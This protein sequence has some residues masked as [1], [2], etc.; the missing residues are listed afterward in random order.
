MPPVASTAARPRRPR[1]IPLPRCPEGELVG[2]RVVIARPEFP[3]PKCPPGR[4]G[5][6][7]AA[8]VHAPEP[9]RYRD[10]REAPR[11]EPRTATWVQ[12][13]AADARYPGERTFRWADALDLLSGGEP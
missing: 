3:G 9:R 12:V 5:V 4:R 6:V 2:A 11:E 1:A 7:V 10:G 8:W 13:D